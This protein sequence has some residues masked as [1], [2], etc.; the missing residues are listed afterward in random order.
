M[1]Q[2]T[3][4]KTRLVMRKMVEMAIEDDLI[5]K[6]IAAK[7]TSPR[8]SQVD[9]RPDEEKIYLRKQL[10]EM[11]TYAQQEQDP[12]LFTILTLL[13][14]TGMR[15]GEMRGLEKRDVHLKTKKLTIRQA[16]T[17]KSGVNKIHPLTGAKTTR[18]YVLGPTKSRFGI[19][20]LYLGDEIM[21]VIQHWILYLKKN[22]TVQYRSKLLFPNSKGGI[23]RDDV[24]NQKFRRFKKKYHI[25]SKYNLYRFR[26]T[27]CTNLFHEKV[28]IKTV[29]RLMGD[30]TV[31]VILEVYAHVMNDDEKQA[32]KSINQAYVK[33]LPDLFKKK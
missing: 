5:H 7:V 17:T 21:A 19:R 11:L 12:Q 14:F 22:S 8:S 2:S 3:I 24:L 13:A 15:P 18:E 6:N 30:A 28:D 31:D 1:S 32:S 33:M 27:F 10:A 16:A 9:I 23:L 26:H 25:N 4:D 20:T 29:Q